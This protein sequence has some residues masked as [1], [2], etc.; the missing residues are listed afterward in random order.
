MTGR[1]DKQRP[2]RKALRALRHAVEGL[3]PCLVIGLFWLLPVDWASNLGG[4][5][6]RQVG[7]RLPISRRALQHLAIA[8]PHLPAAD[9]RRIVPG[10]WANLGRL[11]A[12]YPPLG[13]TAYPTSV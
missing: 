1:A 13:T 5:L 7:T 4:W 8:F 6:A 12:E 10:M 2:W 3:L 9:R 11:V